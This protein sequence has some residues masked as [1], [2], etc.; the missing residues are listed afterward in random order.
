[1]RGYSK[2]MT[3]LVMLAVMFAIEGVNYLIQRGK[4]EDV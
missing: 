3:M 1:M 4:G 2:S